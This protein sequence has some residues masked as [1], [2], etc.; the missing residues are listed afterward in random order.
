MPHCT[1]VGKAILSMLTDQQVASL[2]KRT[3]MPAR[4]DNTLT[5]VDAMLTTLQRARELGYTLDDGEQE[6][7]VR[8]VSV[9]LPGL[10]FLAAISVSGPSSRVTME[11]VPR[12]APELQAVAADISR[13]YR[14]DDFANLLNPKSVDSAS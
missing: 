9:P 7:G 3:G 2:L 5:S 14:S 12:I 11:D 13:R 8:C 6:P 4:T 1:G 10:P